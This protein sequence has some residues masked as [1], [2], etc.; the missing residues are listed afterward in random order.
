MTE[1]TLPYIHVGMANCEGSEDAEGAERVGDVVYEDQVPAQ[2][3]QQH[4]LPSHL[5]W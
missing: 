3:H 4:R 1:A 5:N 2:V